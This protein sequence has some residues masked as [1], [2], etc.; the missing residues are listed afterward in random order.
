MRNPPPRISRFE[1]SCSVVTL[2][3]KKSAPWAS[4]ISASSDRSDDC[5]NL[6]DYAALLAWLPLPL[7]E[8]RRPSTLRSV[9]DNMTNFYVRQ[10][11]ALTYK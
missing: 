6:E 2:L 4:A 7:L 9:E 8:S 1:S 10:A 5:D 3:P 11:T